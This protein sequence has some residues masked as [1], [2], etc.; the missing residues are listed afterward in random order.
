MF[1]CL[2]RA[3]PDIGTTCAILLKLF[4]ACNIVSKTSFFRLVGYFFFPIFLAILQFLALANKSGLVIQHCF[5][6]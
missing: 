2:M 1:D 3:D 6:E 4:F 5:N